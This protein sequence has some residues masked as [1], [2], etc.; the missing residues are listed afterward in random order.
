MIVKTTTLTGLR[1]RA[2]KSVSMTFTTMQELSS[3]DYMMLDKLFQA[4]CVIAIKES[5][6][7]DVE[8]D[9]LD[10]LDV[11]LYDSK[12]SQ[13]KRIRNTLWKVQ[14]SELGRKPNDDEFKEFYRVKTNQIIEHYKKFINEFM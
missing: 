5:D 6:F 11:D 9:D 12:K 13:S 4:D 2:D 14:E 3:N 8:L 1:R 10:S 7:V